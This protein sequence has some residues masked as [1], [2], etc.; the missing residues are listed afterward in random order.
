MQIIKNTIEYA[1]WV[2][3]FIPLWIMEIPTRD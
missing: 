1:L 2:A 3:I